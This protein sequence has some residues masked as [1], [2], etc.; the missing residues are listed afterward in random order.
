[1]TDPI[2]VT[3][4]ID[5]IHGATVSAYG[6]WPYD[7]CDRERRHLLADFAHRQPWDSARRRFSAH[8]VAVVDQVVAP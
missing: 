7:K 8:V 3:V 6:P 2:V 5:P 1:M 4:L